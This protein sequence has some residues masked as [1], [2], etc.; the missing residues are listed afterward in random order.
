P[1]GALTCGAGYGCTNGACVPMGCVCT[2]QYQPVCGENGHTYGN[3]CQAGCAGAPVA[4]QGECGID[5]DP[6]G[7]ISGLQCSGG[8]CRYAASTWEA[9]YPDAG[10]TCRGYNY[11]DAP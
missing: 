11:C 2:E 8:R 6:C 3:A 1:T 5:G 9:P 7:G 10:G 4:H